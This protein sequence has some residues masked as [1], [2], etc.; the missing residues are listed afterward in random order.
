MSR[1]DH[2]L[3]S[4]RRWAGR[5]IGLKS[6]SLQTAKPTSQSTKSPFCTFN[7]TTKS[8]FVHI[9]KVAGSSIEK[10]LYDSWGKVGHHKAKTYLEA[11]PEKFRA[12]YS[13]AFV[14]NPYDRFV[15]AYEYL[16]QGGRNQYD[17]DWSDQYIAPHESFSSFVESLQGDTQRE[18]VLQWSHFIPQFDFVCDDS[19]RIIVDFIGH[20]ETIDQ[21]FGHVVSHL[22]LDARLPHINKTGSRS[23]YEAY[24]D[25]KSKQI[26]F[27]AYRQDFEMFGYGY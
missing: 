14:R 9:P 3:G 15:S 4:A 8:L 19:Q 7:H 2:I 27:D 21:D 13:F 25:R 1:V 10:A 5:I 24:F 18:A 17:K 22:A 26:V 11:D 6:P 12:Y 20:Y 23:A 16:R